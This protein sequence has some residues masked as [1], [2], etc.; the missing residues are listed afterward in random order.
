M[1]VQEIDDAG[2]PIRCNGELLEGSTVTEVCLMSVHDPERCRA[3]IRLDGST[4]SVA[5]GETIEV[6]PTPVSDLTITGV[7][8]GR[9]AS[10]NS[11]IIRVENMTAPA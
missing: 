2:V 1:N 3:E 8:I 5:E 7:M 9:E 10:K 4:R 6:G 11:L